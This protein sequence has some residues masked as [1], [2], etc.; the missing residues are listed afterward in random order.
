M[1]GPLPAGVAIIRDIGA[2]EFVV[3]ALIVLLLFGARRL[4]EVARST[5]TALKEFRDGLRSTNPPGSS[6]TD[7][8]DAS[9]PAGPETVAG[10]PHRER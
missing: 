8:G 5:G 2:G 10:E 1:S 3:I 4:P 6:A 7:D 9:R